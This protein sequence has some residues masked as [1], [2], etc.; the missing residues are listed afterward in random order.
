VGYA[1]LLTLL[2]VGL[3]GALTDIALHIYRDGRPTGTRAQY[4]A[5]L[6][7]GAAGGFVAYHLHAVHGVPNH[8]MGWALGFIFPDVA[9]TYAR[10]HAP[11][12]GGE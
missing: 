3:F 10:K 7:L 4:L 1:L 6:L 12:V 11:P 9:E 2:A 8:L 5:W